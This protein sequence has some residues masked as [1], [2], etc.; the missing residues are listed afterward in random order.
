MYMKYIV[1]RF[2]SGLNISIIHVL[3]LLLW[4]TW[5]P[6]PTTSVYCGVGVMLLLGSEPVV[7]VDVAQKKVYRC[8][9]SCIL[10]WSLGEYK[11]STSKDLCDQST[12]PAWCSVIGKHMCC[13][14]AR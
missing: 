3:S 6:T 7:H 1:S 10:C 2:K 13:K 8:Q 14:I 4:I 5:S 12:Q 11:L 9:V